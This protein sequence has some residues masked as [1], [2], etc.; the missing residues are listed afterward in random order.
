MENHLRSNH[1][2]RLGDVIRANLPVQSN[3]TNQTIFKRPI[4]YTDVIAPSLEKELSEEPNA[5]KA[6]LILALAKYEEQVAQAATAREII[7][8]DLPDTERTPWLNQIG[9]LEHV[10]GLNS[11]VLSS[12]THLPAVSET[13]LQKLCTIARNLVSDLNKKASYEMCPPILRQVLNSTRANDIADDALTFSVLPMTLS[14]YSLE[15]HHM[16]CYLVRATKD[17]Q[18][19]QHMVSILTLPRGRC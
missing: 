7:P 16:L 6:L 3:I 15:L 2:T 14:L 17:E 19:I 12:A 8:R 1:S 5:D 4:H 9:W 13:T 11:R 18:T 10:K